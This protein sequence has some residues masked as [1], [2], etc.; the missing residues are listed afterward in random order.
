MRYSPMIVHVD[1]IFMVGNQNVSDISN[2]TALKAI[3]MP[4]AYSSIVMLA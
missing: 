2:M 1:E 3:N 4:V